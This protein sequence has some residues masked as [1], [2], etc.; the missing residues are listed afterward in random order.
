MK[1]TLAAF[2]AATKKEKDLS[3]GKDSHSSGKQ[4]ARA[5]NDDE[6]MEHYF[7][8]KFLTSKNLLE[9]EVSCA[10]RRYCNGPLISLRLQLAD[11][12]FRRQILVQMLILYQFLLSFAPTEHARLLKRTTNH[13]ALLNFVLSPENVRRSAVPPAME[14][15]PRYFVQEKWIRDLKEKTL[16]E[17]DSMEGG[18]RFRQSI[19]LILK[20]E[21]NWVSCLALAPLSRVS[22]MSFSRTD[23]LEAPK[24]YSFRTPALARVSIRRRAQQ[25]EGAQSKTKGIYARS[26]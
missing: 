12:T 5:A 18:R 6:G 11:P 17:M 23:R 8:P 2:A 25:A 3:G 7:F 21:Q 13:S 9:L 10:A 26:R 15:N 24:L 16:N 19:E 22:L 4:K 20:R 14:A 1:K